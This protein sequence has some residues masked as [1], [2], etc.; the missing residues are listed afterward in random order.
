[1]SSNNKN[2]I[3][4]LEHVDKFC[5]DVLRCHSCTIC[6]R[7]CESRG[8][9]V[10]SRTSTGYHL[11]PVQMTGIAGAAMQQGRELVVES[12][13]RE[14]A[15][16]DEGVDLPLDQLLPPDLLAIPCV[17]PVTS[18]LL[19]V[20]ELLFADRAGR[21]MR[22]SIKTVCRAAAA[23]IAVALQHFSHFDAQHRQAMIARQEDML[24]A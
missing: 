19:A 4:F 1:M 20:I 7:D 11:A 9:L 14:N 24:Q 23:H 13:T 22:E 10:L 2:L 16:Y 3:E 17:H 12:I 21:E 8:M 15:L 18:Q 5:R 6:L